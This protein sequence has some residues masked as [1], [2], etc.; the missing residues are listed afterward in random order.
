MK[1]LNM[2]R[3]P[4]VSAPYLDPLRRRDGESAFALML[5]G[6]SREYVGDHTDRH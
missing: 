1:M 3:R 4:R 5:P 2:S 6:L